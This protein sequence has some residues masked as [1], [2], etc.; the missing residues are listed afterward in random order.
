[1]KL[2]PGASS[3]VLMLKTFT[4]EVYHFYCVFFAIHTYRNQSQRER[5]R[6]WDE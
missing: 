4:W 2:G 6:E 1:M 3:L 5:E